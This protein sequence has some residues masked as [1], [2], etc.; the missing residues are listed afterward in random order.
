MKSLKIKYCDSETTCHGV[1]GDL[2]AVEV[3]GLRR[4]YGKIDAVRGVSFSIPSGCV[5]GLLGKNGAG[6]TSIIEMIEGLRQPDAGTIKVYGLD[7]FRDSR[8]VRP[9]I[10]AQLQTISIPDKLRV[11]ESVK[12][13]A[14]F[15]NDPVPCRRLLDLV[16]LWHRRGSYFEQLSGGE[17]QRVA[18]ALALVG[19]PKI[20]FLDEPTTGLDAETRRNLHDL[21]LQFRDQ[22]RTIVLTT[23]YIEEAEKLCDQVG[24][25]DR[26]VMCVNGSPKKLIRQIGE[27]E[28]LEIV[29]RRHV[30]VEDLVLW[31]GPGVTIT[32]Q[33]EKYV[34]C[35]TSGGKMLA[36]VAVQADRHRNEIM[37]ARITHASLEDV[38]LQIIG[39]RQNQSDLD[40]GAVEPA[41][42][43]SR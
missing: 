24:V 29:F 1:S 33:R 15:Y 10:G 8:R 30:A 41:P 25:L 9:L 14:S 37:E 32:K 35:G 7:P 18:I 26:G 16:G 38:Y 42:F 31:V 12:L 6:K 4:S 40:V 5:W 39:E 43:L 22:G 28:R 27:G 34:L 2:P 19:D 23:H 36:A 11:E 13:F 17:K 20:L 21:I 3:E